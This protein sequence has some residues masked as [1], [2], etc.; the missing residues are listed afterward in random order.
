[1]KLYKRTVSRKL[2]YRSRYL[3]LSS[4]EQVRLRKL[5]KLIVTL[6]SKK[7]V[8]GLSEEEERLLRAIIVKYLSI[9]VV[10]IDSDPLQRRPDRK[11][12]IDSFSS[13]ECNINFSF[14][15]TEL[16]RLL[17]L[18]KLPT[19]CILDNGISMSDEEVLL[20]GYKIYILIHDM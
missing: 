4:A 5:K 2:A 14:H 12:T 11:R 16:I 18:L 7:K 17:A 1:M 10:D 20:R 6:L 19:T 3:A 15:K 9:S 13:S 8:I